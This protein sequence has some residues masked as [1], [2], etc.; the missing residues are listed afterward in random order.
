MDTSYPLVLEIVRNERDGR[1]KK[2]TK[3]EEEKRR[4]KEGKDIKLKK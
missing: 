3:G 4:R 2:K 1:K